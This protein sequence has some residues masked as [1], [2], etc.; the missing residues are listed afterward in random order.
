MATK[1]QITLHLRGMPG[2]DLGFASGGGEDPA[3]IE[4]LTI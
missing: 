1:Q 2:L 3:K 4:L